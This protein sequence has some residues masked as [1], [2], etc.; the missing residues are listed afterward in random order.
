MKNFGNVMVLGRE[1]RRVSRRRV[2]EDR[3]VKALDHVED[4]RR[5]ARR[6]REQHGA[7]TGIPR[8]DQV[9]AGA[10]GEEELGRGE[11][12]VARRETEDVDAPVLRGEA[13]SMTR[14]C[15]PRLQCWSKTAC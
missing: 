11:G 8:E 9:A 10:E 4:V 14:A 5:D 7:R 2:V 3:R 1:H 12:A 15:R 13:S 6:A